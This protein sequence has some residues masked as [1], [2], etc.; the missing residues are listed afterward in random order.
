L[1][2]WASVQDQIRDEVKQGLE[3]TA[4]TIRTEDVVVETVVAENEPA[5]AIVIE[6]E[7]DHDTTIAISTHGRSG[8][9]RWVL[10]SVTDNVIRQAENALLVIRSRDGEV[11]SG[12]PKLSRVILPLD[13][14]AL[15][16]RLGLTR[17]RWRRCSA[18]VSR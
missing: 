16:G 1:Q 13:G 11:T 5:E 18:S 9:G 7:R 3:D 8:I 17:S 2:T 6:A 10:G 15:P 14:S 4:E 12:S